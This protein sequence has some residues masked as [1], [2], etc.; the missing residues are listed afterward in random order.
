MPVLFGHRSK[1][2]QDELRRRTQAM[3]E[4][5]K[6]TASELYDAEAAHALQKVI[7]APAN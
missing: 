2:W 4:Y 1:E 5:S 7:L 6:L 3:L